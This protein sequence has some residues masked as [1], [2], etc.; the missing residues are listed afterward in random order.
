MKGPFTK[1]EIRDLFTLWQGRLGLAEWDIRV[2]FERIKPDTITMQIH[3]SVNYQRAT[4][5]VQ[6]W[7]V[8]GKPPKEWQTGLG[9]VRKRDVEECV[10]HELLH[11]V[12]GPGWIWA[13]LL[14]GHLDPTVLSMVTGTYDLIEEGYVDML[15]VALVRAWP[16]VSA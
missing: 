2:T 1:R 12:I 13:N 8:T 15:A 6:P 7:V 9:R 3:R 10:V 4:I 16:K 5:K 14:D 11:A